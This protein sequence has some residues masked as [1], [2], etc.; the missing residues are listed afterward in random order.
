[1]FIK[2][3]WFGNWVELT[4]VGGIIKGGAIVGQIIKIKND[5]QR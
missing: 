1:M 4:L 5:L 2:R 3:L